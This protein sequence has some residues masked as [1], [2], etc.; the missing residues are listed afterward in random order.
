MLA[1][2]SSTTVNTSI[3]QSLPDPRALPDMALSLA[4]LPEPLSSR[5]C[6]HTCTHSH[7]PMGH[8]LKPLDPHKHVHVYI[9]K[10]TSTYILTPMVLDSAS[11]VHAHTHTLLT[12]TPLTEHLI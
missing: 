8:T 3:S 5:A 6:T 10:H 11:N 2:L 4:T 7:H 1:H 9:Y 12:H